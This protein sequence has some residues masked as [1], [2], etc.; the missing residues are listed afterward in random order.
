MTNVIQVFAAPLFND[1]A[2]LYKW[3]GSGQE[4]DD[5]YFNVSL[6]GANFSFAGTQ[7]RVQNACTFPLI[8]VNLVCCLYRCD[9][10]WH[11]PKKIMR[12]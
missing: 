3:D 1:V 4:G 5:L 12:N 9:M 6:D 2:F 7:T 11:A 8:P 10:R